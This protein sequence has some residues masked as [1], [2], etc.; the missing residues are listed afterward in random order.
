ML[1][2]VAEH[3]LD[4]LL[5]GLARQR[6]DR[7]RERSSGVTWPS[8]IVLPQRDPRAAA[9]QRV[10]DVGQVR[11][12]STRVRASHRDELAVAEA[13]AIRQDEDRTAPVAAAG[14]SGRRRRNRRS[15]SRP[16]DGPRAPRKRCVQIRLRRRGS[17]CTKA[18]RSILPSATSKCRIDDRP[19]GSSTHAWL[20]AADHRRAAIEHRDEI[21][22]RRVAEGALQILTQAVAEVVVAEQ[23]LELAH[24]DRRLLID[25]RAVE[26]PASFR[27]SS[28]W[29]IALVPGV[30]STSYAAG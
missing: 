24:H 8:S 18:S 26:L 12:I 23:R 28:C 22:P 4:V 17:R 11:L 2:R 10:I 1:S 9:R 30:R 27:L 21:G 3:A 14:L 16:L 5:V 19:S 25:D 13:A 15:G 6:C 29:R 20:Q 7:D